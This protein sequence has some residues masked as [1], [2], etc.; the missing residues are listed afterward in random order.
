[1]E[2]KRS[3]YLGVKWFL[4]ALIFVNLSTAC[5][6]TASGGNASRERHEPGISSPLDLE[7]EIIFFQSGDLKLRG[8]LV[9]PTGSG[10]F[11]LLVLVHGSEN[12]SAVDTYTQHYLFARSGFATLV[13]DKRG[14]GQSEGKFTG[15]FTKLADD[16]VAAIHHMRSLNKI[17]GRNIGLVAF[18]QGGWV[19]PLA[20]TKSNEIKF[21]RK[22]QSIQ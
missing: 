3:L 8:K 22:I 18:S 2:K 13:F 15:S 17:D 6:E 7:E 11:P 1:M 20:A 14:T 16:V 12:L 4:V 19:A 21:I 10:P 5:K 9:N